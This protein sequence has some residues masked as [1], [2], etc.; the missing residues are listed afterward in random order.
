MAS[1]TANFTGAD[2][3]SSTLAVIL[4][5]EEIIVAISGTYGAATIELQRERGAP[6]SGSWELLR[7][8]QLGANETFDEQIRQFW[9]NVN[10]RLFSRAY[11]SGTVDVTISDGVRLEEI[12][13][14]PEGRETW[15]I[16]EDG[17]TF[18]EN[19]TVDGALAIAGTTVTSTPAEL[20]LLDGSA[21]ANSAASVAAILD[22]GGDLVTA[23]NVGTSAASSVKEYGDGFNHVTVLT[24]T[25]LAI[26]AITEGGADAEGDLIYTFPAG[27]ILLEAVFMDLALDL[28]GTDQ[29]AVNADMGIGTTIAS[30]NVSVLSG[31]AAFEDMMTGRATTADGSA[32]NSYAQQSTGGGP[33]FIEAADDHTVHVNI[34]AT[35][36]AQSDGDG[37]GAYT[38]TVTIIWKFLGA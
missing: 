31:T 27:N 25:A 6:G 7:S 33:M 19:V 28:D 2:Q 14:D 9:P 18:A 11:T 1:V 17:V 38:G 15:R 32:A 8:F 5:G 16:D 30:G 10:Y 23:S 21:E 20:N 26:P 36:A 22:D 13:R 24:A 29:D 12:H 37:T 34:A 3:T 35:W 4:A